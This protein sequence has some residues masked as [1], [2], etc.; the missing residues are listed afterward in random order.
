[1]HTKDGLADK[2][3]DDVKANVAE[4][5][6]NPTK[7]IEGKVSC[8]ADDFSC[9]ESNHFTISDGYLRGRTNTT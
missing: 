5:M 3:L 2:F 1:M 6:K 8:L 9:S 4:L 7:P